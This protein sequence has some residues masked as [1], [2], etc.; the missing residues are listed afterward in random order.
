M[1]LQKCLQEEESD[2]LENTLI[3]REEAL[4]LA[5]ESLFSKVSKEVKQIRSGISNRVLETEG[6]V[7]T[8]F[9][10]LP[11]KIKQIKSLPHTIPSFILQNIQIY[12]GIVSALFN[13]PCY[14]HKMLKSDLIEKNIVLDWVF[15]IYGSQVDDERIIAHILSLALMCLE[16]EVETYSLKQQSVIRL[17]SSF[18]KM[19]NF[20]QDIQQE[21]ISFI[22]ELAEYVLLQLVIKE[23]HPDYNVFRLSHSAKHKVNSEDG[24]NHVTEENDREIFLEGGEVENVK[25]MFNIE[26]YIKHRHEAEKVKAQRLFRR[27]L[28]LIKKFEGYLKSLLSRP[29]FCELGK[30]ST[31]IRFFNS[32]IIEEYKKAAL[33]KA[34][35]KEKS[36][37]F[38]TSSNVRRAELLVLDIFFGRM[39]EVILNYK[40]YG[41]K[42]PREYEDILS[43]KNLEGIAML[44]TKY[45]QKEEVAQGKPF[46]SL[47]DYIT[48]TSK[49][50]PIIS[51]LIKGMTNY[52]SYD[53]TAES[54]LRTVED[55]LKL[56]EKYI[57]KLTVK[58]IIN[59]QNF[60]IKN[61]NNLKVLVRGSDDPLYVL[62]EYFKDFYL[63]L[64]NFSFDM[65]AYKVTLKVNSK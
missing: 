21:N 3:S 54:L 2:H 38:D 34:S 40:D 26:Y 57:Y 4:I 46:T 32:R 59:L 50:T 42:I 58:D 39:S 33:K 49:S 63:S 44:I 65:L 48:V 22:K 43:Q 53:I 6:V 24:S 47:N 45:F 51:S 31:Q 52:N 41:I 55:S 61:R 35:E 8:S 11:K 15:K 12:E 7:Q 18:V 60:L 1:E 20:I 17:M 5:F 27:C 56:K 9:N 37:N 19:Y 13:H 23:N 62:T 28:T 29:D 10:A 25:D 14:F 30:I 36:S 16:E 64:N